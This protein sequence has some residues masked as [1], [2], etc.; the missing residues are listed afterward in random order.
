MKRTALT[1]TLAGTL[2]LAATG[3]A[4][5][6]WYLLM[7][8]AQGGHICAGAPYSQWT[9]IDSYETSRECHAVERQYQAYVDDTRACEQ[10]ARELRQDGKGPVTAAAVTERVT[11][12]TC[13]S[14]EDPHLTAAPA[15]V[16]PSSDQPL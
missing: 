16:V 3:M 11:D 6:D 1:L 7:P 2:M 14:S 5:A 8:P 13:L 10:T 15:P 4:H 9:L 12:A